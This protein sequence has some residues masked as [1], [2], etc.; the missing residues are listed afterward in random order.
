MQLPLTLKLTDALASANAGFRLHSGACDVLIVRHKDGLRSSQWHVHLGRDVC[1]QSNRARLSLQLD[2]STTGLLMYV[3]QDNKGFFKDN[4]HELRPSPHQIDALPLKSGFTEGHFCVEE[5]DTESDTWSAKGKIAVGVYVW[6]ASDRIVVVDVEN[7][8]LKSSIWRKGADVVMMQSTDGS[9]EH[10]REGIGQLL[11]YLDRAGYR[12]LLLKAAPITRADRVRD[13]INTIRCSELE[14]Y[15]RG[16]AVP[17]CPIMTTQV[18]NSGAE[19]NVP[20]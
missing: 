18:W 11:S 1:V 14:Q 5:Q 13:S 2:G 10:V 16:A 4:D 15:G 9:V 7:V 12:V 20:C 6:D 17:A 8:V 3:D 19:P